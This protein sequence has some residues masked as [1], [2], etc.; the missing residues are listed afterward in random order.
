SRVRHRSRDDGAEP[1]EAAAR[2]GSGPA[3]H[4]ALRVSL[5]FSSSPLSPPAGGGCFILSPFGRSSFRPSR[6][7]AYNAGGGDF[8]G[9]WGVWLRLVFMSPADGRIARM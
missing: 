2:A 1:P 6:A 3:D 4:G 5:E 8:L 9:A 7:A